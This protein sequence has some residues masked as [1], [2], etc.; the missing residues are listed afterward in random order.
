MPPAFLLATS[1]EV[2]KP[3]DWQRIVK[4]L[5][6]RLCVTNATPGLLME[7]EISGDMD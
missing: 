4:P 1:P 3:D 5:T 7:G 2:A 6:L